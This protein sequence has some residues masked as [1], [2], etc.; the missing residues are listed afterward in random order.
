MNIILEIEGRI[1]R[2]II[3]SLAG[4]QICVFQT[5]DGLLFT[6]MFVINSNSQ[7]KLTSICH[8]TDKNIC[9]C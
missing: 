6:G 4:H 7:I 3:N 5:A 9:G 8:L 1:E 2:T